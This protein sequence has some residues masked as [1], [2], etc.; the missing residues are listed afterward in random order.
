MKD[1][2]PNSWLAEEV[3]RLNCCSRYFPR[4]A[5]NPATTAISMQA[6]RTMHVNTGLESRCLVTFGITDN[7][8]GKRVN[9][10]IPQTATW[11]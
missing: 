5:A 9:N 7:E 4:K 6:A 8:K 2:L 11:F 10:T 1:I 3:V